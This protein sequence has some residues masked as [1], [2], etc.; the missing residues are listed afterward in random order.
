HG[1]EGLWMVED[2]V[3]SASPDGTP[4]RTIEDM[5]MFIGGGHLIET[6]GT[7]GVG[8]P[9]LLRGT[10]GLGSWKHV[11]GRHYTVALRFIR[12]DGDDDSFAGTQT[13]AKQIKVR[14]DG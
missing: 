6:P 14:A 1:I 9:P 10:P 13:A 11:E 7:L 8:A 3:L 5:N 4:V 2:H 12:F